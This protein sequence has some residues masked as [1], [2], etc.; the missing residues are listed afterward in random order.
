VYFGSPSAA[1][2]AVG[3]HAEVAVRVL[4]RV[5]H[6]HQ[7]RH[8]ARARGQAREVVVGP[9]I[10]VDADERGVA[11]HAQ[12]VQHAA[13]G[14]QR[15]GAFVRVVQAQSPA[16]AVARV[17][18]RSGSGQPR[19]VEHHLAHSDRGELLQVPLDQALAARALSKRLGR[20]V[21]ER[22]HAL[23]LARGGRPARASWPRHADVAL[24]EHALDQRDQAPRFPDS[25]SP[26]RCV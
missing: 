11:E 9:H 13:A 10:A 6:H 24:A 26:T 21:G 4:R 17:P 25:G 20:V 16:R 3:L 8:R 2:R 18:A 14:L 22:A 5:C 23:A 7:V 1:Q 12:R 19:D 15:L